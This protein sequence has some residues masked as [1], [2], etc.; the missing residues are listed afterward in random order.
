[1]S[2]QPH[3]VGG[4]YQLIPVVGLVCWR[5]RGGSEVFRTTQPLRL[6]QIPSSALQ[7]ACQLC[8]SISNA[9]RPG[10]QDAWAMSRCRAR[11]LIDGTALDSRGQT[12]RP[13]CECSLRS[14]GRFGLRG[15]SSRTMVASLLP[16]SSS[17]T[18]GGIDLADF[19]TTIGLRDTTLRSGRCSVP[20]AR[21]QIRR[22]PAFGI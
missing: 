7:V 5:G 2:G 6:A 19:A 8:L 12:R 3:N 14:A 18:C 22:Q 21:T 16:P 17:I 20:R 15:G 10:W 1:M 9:V 11:R 4:F 13:L